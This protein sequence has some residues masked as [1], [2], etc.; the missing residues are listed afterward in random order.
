MNDTTQISHPVN[1]LYLVLIMA[2]VTMIVLV[3]AI[4]LLYG[5][6]FQEEQKRLVD[7]AQSRARLIEAVAR[8]DRLHS[9]DEAA[10]AATLSQIR[11]AHENF[12]GFGKTGEFTLAKRE[13]DNIVF[14]LSHRHHDLSH[15][16]PVSMHSDEAAP[17]RLALQGKSGSIVGPDYRGEQVLAAFEPVAGLNLGVVAKIDMREIRAPFIRAGQEIAVTGLL[18]VVIG[19]WAFRHITIPIAHRL[20]KSEELFRNTFANAAIA[21]A[22]VS[23]RGDWLRVNRALCDMLGYRCD[24]LLQLTF[25]DIS[26]PDDAGADLQLLKDTLAGERDSYSMEKGYI[27]KDG[28]TV[29][30]NLTVALVRKANGEPDYF[31]YAIADI[32]ALKCAEASLRELNSS[33]AVKNQALHEAMAT[34]KTISGVVPLC[35]WCGKTIRNDNGE[36]VRIETYFEEHT[37]A[38]ISHGMCPD[39]KASFTIGSR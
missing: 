13:G 14:L 35:A 29:S 33:L 12:S 9:G 18:L 1:T 30:A 16:H 31:I 23:V 28:T 34:I 39:C 32:S 37:D 19:A 17:M 38:N 36:W 6:A 20:E 4:A 26:C 7:T 8:F 11:E 10:F 15:P 3:T 25:Q 21:L 5:G 2:T 22:H 27:R 24:E